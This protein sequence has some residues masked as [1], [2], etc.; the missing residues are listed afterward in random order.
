MKNQLLDSKIS[1]TL[2]RVSTKIL[3]LLGF[4]SIILFVPRFSFA[5]VYVPL[6]EYLGYFDSNGIYTVVG[7]VKNENDF[8]IIPTITVSVIDDSKQ[9][10]KQF[11][12]FHLLQTEI[13]FKI[14]F[15]EVQSNTPESS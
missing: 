3:L 13:P 10:Q 5:E 6:H 15:S 1:S 2:S 12:M 7:N 9:F 11:N 14:K 8:A 4:F